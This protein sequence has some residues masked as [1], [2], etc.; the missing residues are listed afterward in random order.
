MGSL[1]GGG[2]GARLAVSLPHHADQHRPEDAILLAVD[3]QFGEVRVFG[4]PV[5]AIA[6]ARSKSGSHQDVEKL[7]AWLSRWP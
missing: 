7:D 6:S 5:R 1:C 3:Q 2:L 4:S